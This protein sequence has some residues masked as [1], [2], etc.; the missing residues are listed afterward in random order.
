MKI[1]FVW[2]KMFAIN[3]NI[4]IL[5]CALSLSRTMTNV[6]SGSISNLLV[7]SFDGFRPDFLDRDITPNM[8]RIRR[9]GVSADYMRPVFPTKTLPNHFSISTGMHVATHGITGKKVYDRKLN[10]EI[11]YGDELYHYNAQIRP[12]WTITE[13]AGKRAGCMMWSG[14]N[15]PY[16][17]V[18]CT[19]TM[20]YNTT[21]PWVE[22]IDTALSWFNHPKT[23]VNL[24]M[25]Y[26]E[27]PDTL[28]HIYSPD[29]A[30][31]SENIAEI[32]DLVGYLQSKLIELNL[33][34]RLN[35]IYISDHGM[36]SISRPN[37]IN[38]TAWLEPNSYHMYGT[39]PV[40]QVVPEEGKEQLILTNLTDASKVNGHFKVY[41]DADLPDRWKY[42][43]QQRCGPITVV[44]DLNYGFQDRYR[45]AAKYESLH[46]I[47]ISDDQRYGNYGYDNAEPMMFA[48][49]FA[50]GPKLKQQHTVTPFDNVDLYNLFSM[51]LDIEPDPNN[52]TLEHI[53]DIFVDENRNYWIWVSLV[54]LA[55]ILIICGIFL[56]I[57]Q[58]RKRRILF[59][60]N[61]S[62][63][64]LT[65][66]LVLI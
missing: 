37:Y 30:I 7:V 3:L 15:F 2:L 11:R 18:T 58:L 9:R 48:M 59:G 12:I 35:I 26:I 61:S 49:F 54:V 51:I 65:P 14:S 5:S 55:T 46:N 6:V 56:T 10:K 64:S 24:V 4:L 39:S 47:V 62:S 34:D 19:F 20:A 33:K 36:A 45:I 40:F 50:E 13:K 44:A 31:V 41:S 63:W 42:E 16:D 27:Y 8:N 57:C 1:D 53:L 17:N 32:D 38:L 60:R 22:R 66:I 29:S 25:L 21:V 52:G 43:N 28:E 23:P